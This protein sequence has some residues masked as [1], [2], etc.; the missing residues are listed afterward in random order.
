MA[1]IKCPECGRQISEYA[2]SCPNCGW[3][4]S[5]HSNKTE[6]IER[7]M[8]KIDASKMR[9]RESADAQQEKDIT[10]SQV[11]KRDKNPWYKS[12]LGRIFG[13]LIIITICLTILSDYTDKN[14]D[15]D[16]YSSYDNDTSSSTTTMTTTA[17]P[18]ELIVDT[19]G[20]QIHKVYCTNG[21][22]HFSGSFTGEGNFIVWVLNSNQDRQELVVNEIGDYVVDKTV[23]VGTGYHYIQIECSRGS[24]TMN[25]EGTGGSL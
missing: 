19:D 8:G 4:V 25:W 21:Y 12:K 17:P 9:S 11:V 22:L 1:L 16:F 7:K 20:K 13:V 14:T 6:T 5:M 2:I 10:K 23:Y 15:N 18:D 3:P 24:W